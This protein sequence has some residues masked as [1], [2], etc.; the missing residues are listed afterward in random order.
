MG[1][2][3]TAFRQELS[4]SVSYWGEVLRSG[5]NPEQFIIFLSFLTTLNRS[6][7]ERHII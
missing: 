5:A 1:S 4:R 6:T 7:V 2:Y 3:T